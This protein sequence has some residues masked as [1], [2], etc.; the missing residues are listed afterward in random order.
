MYFN[1]VTILFQS[2]ICRDL[3]Y[4]Y[5]QSPLR[6][7]VKALCEMGMSSDP[8]ILEGSSVSPSH[9]FHHLHWHLPVKSSSKNKSNVPPGKKLWLNPVSTCIL[10]HLQSWVLSLN[11]MRPVMLKINHFDKCMQDWRKKNPKTQSWLTGC[12]CLLHIPFH[13]K[14]TLPNFGNYF[15]KLNSIA[16]S[17]LLNRHTQIIEDFFYLQGNVYALPSTPNIAITELTWQ[18]MVTPVVFLAFRYSGFTG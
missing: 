10:F 16:T 12:Y 11:W 1:G 15:T 2:G 7:H 4:C 17:N 3:Q 6:V 13:K 14:A 5:T 8:H 18:N 9:S